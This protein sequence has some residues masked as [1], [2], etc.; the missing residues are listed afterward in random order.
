MQQGA[1]VGYVNNAQQHLFTLFILLM[2]AR[3]IH[4][5]GSYKFV[6][7]MRISITRIYV[8]ACVCNLVSPSSGLSP[9]PSFWPLCMFFYFETAAV[10][11]DWEILHAHWMV[12]RWGKWR[13]KVIWAINYLMLWFYTQRKRNDC[14]CSWL[15]GLN[16]LLKWRGMGKEWIVGNKKCACQLDAWWR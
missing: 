7:C 8:T 11:S 10:G 12:S 1:V 3:T 9:L 16:R 2:Q 6:Q 13:I 5:K 14:M 15:R 4:T